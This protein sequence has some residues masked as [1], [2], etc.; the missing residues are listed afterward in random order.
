MAVPTLDG[1]LP[2]QVSLA[3]K[4]EITLREL[5]VSDEPMLRSW[6]ASLS[7]QSRY[8]R[9]HGQ[10]LELSPAAWRYLTRIDQHDHVGILA[11]IDGNLVGVAR[12]IRIGDAPDVAEVSFLIGDE[13]HRRGIGTVLRDVLMEI[14]RTRGYSKLYAYVLPENVAIRKLL[15]TPRTVDRGGLLEVAL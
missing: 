1:R 3:D 13:H 6:F 4:T 8:H 2:T 11:L 5:H 15:H 12:M 9:F 10:V 7:Q 14:G